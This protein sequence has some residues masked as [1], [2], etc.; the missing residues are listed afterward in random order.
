MATRSTALDPGWRYRAGFQ[1]TKVLA[2]T[3]LAAL[4]A[5]GAGWWGL[6]IARTWGL[7]EAD[8]GVLK[9]LWQRVAFGS[10]VG[11]LGLA[12]F[13]GMLVYWR[14]YIVS[15]D[16]EPDGTT[17]R[18]GRLFPVP[19]VVVKAADLRVGSKIHTGDSG[20]IGV[21]APWRIGVDAPWRSVYIRGWRWPLLL[22]MRGRRES[23]PTPAT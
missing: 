2:V 4:C 16:V 17:V 20:L 14:F 1:A 8:G 18:L 15:I 11:L 13:A 21:L 6:D 23:T 3:A 10:G 9:P 7:A 5:V 22:D 12:F 19:A